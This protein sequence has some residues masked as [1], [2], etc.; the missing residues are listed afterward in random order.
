MSVLKEFINID[1]ADK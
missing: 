1:M